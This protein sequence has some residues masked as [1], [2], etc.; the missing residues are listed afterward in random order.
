[1]GKEFNQLHTYLMYPL[2]RIGHTGDLKIIEQTTGI[3]RSEDTTGI[4]GFG[5]VRLWHKYEHGNTDPLE[6]L[7]K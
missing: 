3:K 5:A 6:L 7:L 4:T 2:R 1:M